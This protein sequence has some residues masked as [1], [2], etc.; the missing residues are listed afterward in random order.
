MKRSLIIL[1]SCLFTFLAIAQEGK[2][3]GIV[4]DGLTE[5]PLIG[6]NIIATDGASTLPKQRQQVG[7]ATD[8]DGQYELSLEPGSYVIDFQF[9]GY[10]LLKKRVKIT[11]G[12]D[13]ELSVGLEEVAQELGIVTVSASKYEKKF[14]E[15]S[16]TIEVL[17]PE[18]I[19]NT[20]SITLADALPKV[21]GVNLIGEN[22]DIR[23]GS[24]YSGG[25]GSRV[26]M[27]MDGIPLLTPQSEAVEFGALPME[28][29]KQVEVIKGASSALYGSAALNGTINVITDNPDKDHAVKLITYVGLYENPFKGS[30]SRLYWSEKK[31]IFYGLAALYAKKIKR[32]D[33]TFSGAINRDNHYAYKAQRNLGRFNFKFRFRPKKKDNLTIGSN[34]NLSHRNNQFFFLWRQYG[35]TTGR[36]PFPPILGYPPPETVDPECNC[37]DSLAYTPIDSADQKEVSANFDPYLIYFDKKD[38]KHSV[39]T[40]FY[41]L[42]TDITREGINNSFLTFA[43]Y[44]YHGAIKSLGLNFVAGSMLRYSY[45]NAEAFSKRQSWNAAVFF[46]IDKKF[47][48]KL[49]ITGGFRTELYSVDTI[50]VKVIPIGRCGINYEIAP[51]T[52][53]RGSIGQGYR[54]PSIAERFSVLERAGQLVVP[55]ENLQPESSWNAEIGIKQAVRISKWTGYFDV[56]GFISRYH[57]MIEFVPVPGDQKMELI[58]KYFPQYADLSPIELLLKQVYWAENIADVRISGLDVSAFGQGKIFGIKTNFLIGYTFIV[59][60]DLNYDPDDPA[61]ALWPSNILKFRFRHSLK[62]DLE[63]EYK[64]LT[65]GL[66]GIVRSFME[67]IGEFEVAPYGFDA[68]R[69]ENNGADL[70]LDARIGY[71]FPKNIKLAFIA[72]NLVNRMYTTRPGYM[73]PPRNYTFQL[74]YEL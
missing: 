73:E 1:I 31:Q 54:F 51:G 58:Q 34:A 8:I 37:W 43:E 52:Y 74:S 26:L 16:V 36:G 72:K 40:R 10:E 18:F 66:T 69:A 53:L 42:H 20:N 3:F 4:S 44:T 71:T 55:N 32:T 61:Y 6:V 68:F 9:I 17:T 47:W 24:G 29:I 46:Q 57:D 27:M 70:V 33:I 39:R 22:I 13:L 63:T 64:G 65:V 25:A 35:D 21:P 41:Y 11:A 48:E 60:I 59:P 62:A 56:S 7:A 2:I 30:K 15:E 28:N 49:T 50:P 45:I 14:G 23:G 5:E 67:N 19:T 12:E 38:N